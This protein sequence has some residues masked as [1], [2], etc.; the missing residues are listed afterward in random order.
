M[1]CVVSQPVRSLC[2]TSVC[3]KCP[4]YFRTLAPKSQSLRN[5]ICPDRA[6]ID[7]FCRV[8]SNREFS[9]S[10]MCS[11]RPGSHPGETSL[12]VCE[13]RN[14]DLGSALLLFAPRSLLR[15]RVA[16]SKKKI[17]RRMLGV[18]GQSLASPSGK[19][20]DLSDGRLTSSTRVE[21]SAA[22]KYWAQSEFL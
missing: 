2:R 12:R 19:L 15:D 10:E 4:R 8:V 22:K 3:P 1:D 7:D 9:I 21:C 11:R 18:L 13:R 6:L 20:P 17:G 16:E 5:E 14:V